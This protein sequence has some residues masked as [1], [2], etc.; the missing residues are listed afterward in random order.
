[1]QKGLI[2][3]VQNLV[4]LILKSKTKPSWFFF[5]LHLM[6]IKPQKFKKLVRLRKIQH[7]LDMGILKN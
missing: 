3:L 6:F 7:H 2:I 5:A 1:M 4:D